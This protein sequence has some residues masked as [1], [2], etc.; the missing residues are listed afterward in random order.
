MTTARDREFPQIKNDRFRYSRLIVVFDELYR[1]VRPPDVT[2]LVAN[3]TEVVQ[4]RKRRRRT[5]S[6]KPKKGRAGDDDTPVYRLAKHLEPTSFGNP[7]STPPSSDG[8]VDWM[9]DDA[10]QYQDHHLHIGQNEYVLLCGASKHLYHEEGKRHVPHPHRRYDLYPIVV[11]A[12]RDLECMLRRGAFFDL[13]RAQQREQLAKHAFWEPYDEPPAFL[14][15]ESDAEKLLLLYATLCVTRREL[16]SGRRGHRMRLPVRWIRSCKHVIED[17]VRNGFP[18]VYEW[19]L[20][21]RQITW[22][23]GGSRHQ[24]RSHQVPVS[25]QV[26]ES[27]GESQEETTQYDHTHCNQSDDDD[28]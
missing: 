28:E 11:Y 14:S 26:I 24:V 15:D 5:T 25:D 23:E 7:G 19:R 2:D 17:Y 9:D 22:W 4:D 20:A 3:E 10:E 27:D 1:H 21:S 12:R 6:S 16:K 13:T 8:E 18:E